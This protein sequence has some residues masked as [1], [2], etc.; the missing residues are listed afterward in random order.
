M[1]E[2]AVV[3]AQGHGISLAE[4]V[5]ARV[6]AREEKVLDGSWHVFGE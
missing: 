1:K 4:R 5:K 2:E 6:N 3:M